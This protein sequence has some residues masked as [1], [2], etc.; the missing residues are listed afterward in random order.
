MEIPA[1]PLV[2]LSPVQDLALGLGLLMALARGLEQLR[3][4]LA[5]PALEVMAEIELEFRPAPDV[6]PFLP[7]HLAEVLELGQ[8]LEKEKGSAT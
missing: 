3:A 5:A 4:L 7:L 1:D 2:P 6:A 8:E